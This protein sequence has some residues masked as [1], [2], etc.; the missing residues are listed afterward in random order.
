MKNTNTYFILLSI[1]TFLSYSCTWDK[2]GASQDEIMFIPVT[3]LIGQSNAIGLGYESDLPAELKDY[4]GSNWCAHASDEFVP[5]DPLVNGRFGI[6]ASYMHCKKSTASE[7]NVIKKAFGGS[8]LGSTPRKHD[9][10]PSI[11]GESFEKLINFLNSCFERPSDPCLKYNVE[12]IIWIQGEA[13]ANDVQLANDY[14][15]NLKNLIQSLHKNLG[16]EV[17]WKITLLPAYSQLPYAELTN[18][19]KTKLAEEIPNIE[20]YNTDDIDHQ[21]DFV[22]FSSTG[23]IKLGRLLCD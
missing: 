1:C 22:H 3:L 12:E 18:E 11:N 16:Y 13:D 10:D 14:K 20:L 15:E 19:A 6:E 21:G 17:K 23:L 2:I 4:N 7:V 9:W 5:F 8:A